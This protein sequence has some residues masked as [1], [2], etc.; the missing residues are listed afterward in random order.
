MGQRVGPG[1]GDREAAALDLGQPQQVHPLLGEA[2]A[3]VAQVG[4]GQ[5]VEQVQQK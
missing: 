5:A 4:L 3:L 2:G 1:L